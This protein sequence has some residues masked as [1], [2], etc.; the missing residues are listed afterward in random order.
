[1]VLDKSDKAVFAILAISTLFF[2]Y[3]IFT[4][5]WVSG[6]GDTYQH[7]LI[8]KWSWSHPELFFHHWGKPM[9]TLISSPFA[10]FGLKGV[11]V[12]NLLCCLFAA[13]VACRMA[14]LL[15]YANSWLAAI[16]TL[17]APVVFFNLFSTLT[18][19]LGGLVLV[20]ALYALQTKR[21]RLAVILFSVN[22]FV[23]NETI[24]FIPLLGLYLM[25]QGKTK[26][27]TWIT[28]V[29]AFWSVLGAVHYKSLFWIIE[30][31]PYSG[32]KDIYGTGSLTHFVD[33]YDSIV[34][35]VIGWALVIGLL[36]YFA[37]LKGLLKGE[38]QVLFE[39]LLMAITLGY[40]A[41][42]SISWWSGIGGSLGLKRV[43][44]PVI[45]VIAVI[46]VKGVDVLLCKLSSPLRLGLSILIMMI[47]IYIPIERY[48]LPLGTGGLELLANQMS[49]DFKGKN[50]D[51]II[52]YFHPCVPFYME[53][54]PFIDQNFDLVNNGTFPIT[55]MKKGDIIIWDSGIGPQEG[56]TSLSDLPEFDILKEYTNQENERMVVLIKREQ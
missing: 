16:F 46:A 18:E 56:G 10:Q 20:C 8:S 29:P 13:L 4:M 24:V 31:F 55:L 32:A 22:L 5:D 52:A 48:R 1:M 2:L 49:K 12:F 14:K 34:H 44:V 28:L 53:L 19:P 35:M 25:A 15:G 21:Y 26:M 23:R 38:E 39:W 6:G 41:A 45:P 7:F 36:S 9:F 30:Q 47:A 42:H 51:R 40:I 3:Y 33:S 11:E 27:L 17:F 43:L 50:A 54:D 37:K